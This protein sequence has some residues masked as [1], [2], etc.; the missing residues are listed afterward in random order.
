M[1]DAGKKP[2]GGQTGGLGRPAIVGMATRIL[3]RSARA[4]VGLGTVVLLSR[5]LAPSEFGLFALVFFV[6]SLAQILGDSGLRTALVFKQ[7]TSGLE[8]D[9]M[10]WLSVGIGCGLTALTVM[11]ADDIARLFNEPSL[12]GPLRVAASVF[13][14]NS[15]RS[16]PQSLLER[17]FQFGTLAVSEVLAAVVGAVVAIA[18]ALAGEGMMA[19]VG[20][21]VAMAVVPSVMSLW[22]ARY[23]PQLRFSFA[24]VRPLLGFGGSITAATLLQFLAGNIDRPIVGA[25]MSA[26]DL[27]M[28]AVAQQVVTTPLRVIV[29]NVRQISFPIMASIQNENQRM[30]AAHASTLHA[31]MLAMGPLCFGLS[32]VSEPAVRVLLG[33]QWMQAG[34]VIGIAAITALI[35]AM[36][37]LNNA[38]FAAQGRGTYILWM[39]IFALAANSLLLWFLV[40]YGLIA[41]VMG[42]LLY[43]WAAL[44]VDTFFLARLLGCR[45]R[46]LVLCFARPLLASMMMAAAVAAIDRLFL[47]SGASPL[48]RLLLLVPAGAVLYAAALWVVDRR[49]AGVLVGRLKAARG[50]PL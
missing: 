23:V 22:A 25:R 5:F 2:A 4:L 33:P 19:L 27:G 45:R 21:Q 37:G 39:A 12:P 11:F 38:I 20:Q 49:E 3:S 6:V 29:N 50:R 40:P 35:T 8:E 9:S 43:V 41:I 18:M 26:T 1:N 13:I 31:V 7:Q 34:Q 28:L 47:G 17:N 48:L 32:A 16:V 10:F 24:A 15:V 30:Q 44:L 46:D 42:R 14:I 36:G